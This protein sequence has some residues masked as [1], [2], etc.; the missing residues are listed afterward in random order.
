MGVYVYD[1]FGGLLERRSFNELF[2][3]YGMPDNATPVK[4][5]IRVPLT[6]K[7]ASAIRDYGDKAGW[8]EPGSG[9][10]LFTKNSPNVVYNQEYA[11]LL[12]CGVFR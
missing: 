7:L 5:P 11:W 4:Q 2:I 1:D 9:Q 10:N 8:W 6:E 12:F 3:Q